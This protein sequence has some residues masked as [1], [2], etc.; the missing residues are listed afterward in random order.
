MIGDSQL[1]E[2]QF[3]TIKATLVNI[4]K[5][6]GV[7]GSTTFTQK[8]NVKLSIHGHDAERWVPATISFRNGVLQV[9]AT[10]CRRSFGP[11]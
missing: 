4:Q 7:I 5:E 2:K 3:P 9:E 1:D 10:G 8:A 6:S 11:T